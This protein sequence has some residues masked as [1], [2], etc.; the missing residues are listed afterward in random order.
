MDGNATPESHPVEYSNLTPENINS[1]NLFPNQWTSHVPGAN[2]P[3]GVP[4]IQDSRITWMLGEVGDV[5]NY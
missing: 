2:G 3:G 4:L 5:T 1:L